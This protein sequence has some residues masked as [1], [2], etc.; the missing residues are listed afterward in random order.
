MP[1]TVVTCPDGMRVTYSC[2]PREAVKCAWYQFKKKRY[3]TWNYDY[4]DVVSLP[5][6]RYAYQGFVAQ[7]AE[8]IVPSPSQG[9]ESAAPV[10]DVGF[11]PRCDITRE[12]PG[13]K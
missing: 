9:D 11:N 1:V 13:V 3:D 2:C 7:E 5:D 8:G 10:A 4:R 12:N 6:G